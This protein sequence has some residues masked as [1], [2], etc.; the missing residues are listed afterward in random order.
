[1]VGQGTDE[2]TRLKEGIAEN[3]QPCLSQEEHRWL[4]SARLRFGCL[5]ARL[6]FLTKPY[7]SSTITVNV[8]RG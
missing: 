3:R 1:V 7:H 2:A 4:F 5:I 8:E 6:L